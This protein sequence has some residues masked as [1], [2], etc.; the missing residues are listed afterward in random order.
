MVKAAL[1]EPFAYLPFAIY[2]GMD[3]MTEAGKSRPAAQWKRARTLA[4]AIDNPLD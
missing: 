4:E 3:P 1:A 2:D